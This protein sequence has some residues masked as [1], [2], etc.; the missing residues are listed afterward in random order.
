MAC[1]F[2]TQIPT[3]PGVWDS[4]VVVLVFLLA[5]KMA[6]NSRSWE[7]GFPNFCLISIHLFPWKCSKK[8]ILNRPSALHSDGAPSSDRGPIGGTHSVSLALTAGNYHVSEVLTIPVPNTGE[9]ILQ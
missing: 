6:P 5:C 4:L 7:M 8:E 1:T 3:C 9:K 2:L